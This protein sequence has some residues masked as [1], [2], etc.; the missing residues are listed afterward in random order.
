MKRVKIRLRDGNSRL[1]S[2]HALPKVFD[3]ARMQLNAHKLYL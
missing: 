1:I 3:V 2:M